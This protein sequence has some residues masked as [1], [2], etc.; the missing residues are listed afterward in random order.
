MLDSIEIDETYEKP[1]RNE[2]D[3]AQEIE[4]ID[5]NDQ[6]DR[7]GFDYDTG[8][9]YKNG[10]LLYTL[11]NY[12]SVDKDKKNIFAVNES[13]GIAMLGI[14]CYS[15][16]ALD[17]DLLKKF[18]NSN[19]GKGNTVDY[20]TF[21]E[22]EVCGFDALICRINLTFENGAVALG[23]A[24]LIK[25]TNHNLLN[26]IMFLQRVDSKADYEPDFVR[27]LDK[28]KIDED[29]KL[30][31]DTD[32]TSNTVSSSKEEKVTEKKEEQ[33]REVPIKATNFY[34]SSDYAGKSVLVVEYQ[35]TTTES[36]ETYFSLMFTDKVYQN[37]VECTK[38]FM[39]PDVDAQALLTAIQP[40]A[41]YPVK[42]A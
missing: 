32:S 34:V 19:K 21:S 12:Y 15:D 17:K 5:N 14:F 8:K 37:G 38:A 31:E 2:A 18:V 42:Q 4:P 27:M 1:K 24:I 33:P 30:P 7:N 40:G 26:G 29:F 23:N 25:N 22:T 41:T 11:P 10:G 36:R 6:N 20:L 3:S 16:L 35:C 13:D 39:C 28:I 9:K